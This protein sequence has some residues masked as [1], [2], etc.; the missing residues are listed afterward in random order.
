MDLPWSICRW[1][2][3]AGEDPGRVADHQHGDEVELELYR[4]KVEWAHQGRWY[5]WPRQ[6]GWTF[7]GPSFD[8]TLK[9]IGDSQ[10]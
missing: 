1:K 7:F 5:S 9:V 10:P 6:A 3:T 2:L 8:S 4:L